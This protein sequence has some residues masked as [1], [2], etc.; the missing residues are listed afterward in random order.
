MEHTKLP[1]KVEMQ[2]TTGV[3]YIS[4][5]EGQTERGLPLANIRRTIACMETPNKND[6][7]FIVLACNHF[8][9]AVELLNRYYSVATDE[10]EFN[11][12]KDVR[13]FLTKIGGS[14]EQAK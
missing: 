10:E 5:D 12:S 9:E 7:E 8:E 2:E 14:H 4:I 6:A 3:R 1:W 11:L 13:D